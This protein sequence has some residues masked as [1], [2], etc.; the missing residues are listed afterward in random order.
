MYWQRK[1]IAVF[2]AVGLFLLGTSLPAAAHNG[3]VALAQ[4]VEG[5][6]IDGDLSDWP[7]D[8]VHYSIALPE[9]GDK[10]KD[11]EDYKGS[12]RIGFSAQENALYVAVETADESAVSVDESTM[13]NEQDGCEVYVDVEHGRRNSPGVQYSVRGD[14]PAASGPDARV[15]DFAAAVQHGENTHVYEYRIDIGGTSRGKTQLQPGMMLGLDLVV[16]DMD[17]DDSFSWISWGSGTAKVGSPSRRGDVL[18]VESADDIGTVAG[19]VRDEKEQKPFTEFTF[20]VFRDGKS[21]GAGQTDTEGRYS[22]TLF[23]GEYTFKP[24]HRQGVKAFELTGISVR[25]G[26]K[27]TKDFTV[28]PMPFLARLSFLVPAA[29]MAEFAKEYD[30]RIAPLLGQHGLEESYRD[31][32]EVPDNVF[33]RL[34]ELKNQSEMREKHSALDGDSTLTTVLEDLGGRMGAAEGSL[35]YRFAFYSVP[36]GEGRT[37]AA[38]DGQKVDA[39]A[40]EVVAAGSGGDGKGR[41]R[42]WT[43]GAVGSEVSA[44]LQD[45][46]G[47]VWIGT[48][49]GGLTRY[50]GQNFTTFTTRDGLAH[51]WVRAL[52]QD[53]EGNVWIGT[54]GGGLSRY[55]G[56][57]FTTFTTQEGLANNVVSVLMR[58]REGN[59]WIGT[60]GGGV[61]RHDGQNFTTFTAQ[62]GLAHDWIASLMQDREGNIWIG[63]EGGGASHYDGEHFTTFNIR[64]GLAHNWVASLLQD[65]EGNVWVGT[66]GGVSRYD[67]ERFTSFTA[68]DGLSHN[69]VASLVRDGEGRLWIG[70]EGG[71]VSRYDGKRFTSFTVEEGLAHNVVSSVSLDGKG[72]L[73]VGTEGG[74]SAYK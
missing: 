34:F 40:G 49:G 50:D 22:L 28:A 11:E 25:S 16:C 21:A 33:S 43:E 39:G 5:I 70:T 15:E 13:W 27:A 7:Q 56:E 37:A 41:W 52:A 53:S 58:D 38:G 8:L 71:G 6:V 65:G 3:G 72:N 26:E 48:Y 51:N 42:S 17:E 1:K 35:P 68:D 61:S 60:E 69:W 2:W 54:D 23:P 9:Y 55:D 59:V 24:G 31:R 14:D 4:L 32:P 44:I 10:P 66:L 20:E 45:G 67:G 18:L 73:W 46:E 12:F 64:D 63:T 36:A 19:T 74:V 47:N 30:K 29:Q 62:D 57:S